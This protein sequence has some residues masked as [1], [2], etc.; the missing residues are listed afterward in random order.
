[1]DARL[2]RVHGIIPPHMLRE[3]AQ[4]GDEEQRT[5]ALSTLAVSENLRGR[6]EALGG[7][8]L[9]PSPGEERRAVYDAHGRYALPGSLIRSEGGA[10]TNDIAADEAYDGAG[11]TYDFYPAFSAAT[12][13]TAGE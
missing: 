9:V 5:W 11:A 7:L 6:R 3:I 13:S 8:R 4:R 1:M 2:V 12:R 10:R